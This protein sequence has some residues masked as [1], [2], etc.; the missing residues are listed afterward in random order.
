MLPSTD[1]DQLKDTTYMDALVDARPAAAAK[2]AFG[3]PSSIVSRMLAR[4]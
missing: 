4:A 1:P 3:T 2:A